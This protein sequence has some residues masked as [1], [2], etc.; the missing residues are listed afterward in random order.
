MLRAGGVVRLKLMGGC[1]EDFAAAGGCLRTSAWTVRKRQHET[2]VWAFAHVVA[3]APIGRDGNVCDGAF[4]ENGASVG[5]RVTMKNQVMIFEGVHIARDILLGP[6]SAVA[7]PERSSP[8][9]VI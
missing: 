9:V 4:V 6:A 7:I 5:D 2:R 3:G 1:G 8:P